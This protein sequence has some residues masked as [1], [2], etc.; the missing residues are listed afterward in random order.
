MKRFCQLILAGLLFA[1]TA[2]AD[3]PKPHCA[4][5]GW[6]R[7]SCDANW[8]FATPN[9]AKAGTTFQG[10]SAHT[11]YAWGHDGAMYAILNQCHP[12][13]GCTGSVGLYKRPSDPAA[14]KV[15]DI[16]YVTGK[17]SA[18]PEEVRHAFGYYNESFRLPTGMQTYNFITLSQIQPASVQRSIAVAQGCTSVAPVT[19]VPTVTARCL[20]PPVRARRSRGPATSDAQKASRARPPPRL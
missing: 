16:Y 14:A 12:G 6:Y 15:W 18:S 3:A 19:P 10:C 8:N 13:Q 5:Y 9:A 20:R 2:T 17:G 1:D 7:R 11:L 4:Q